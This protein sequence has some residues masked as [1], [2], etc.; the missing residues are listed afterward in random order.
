[1]LYIATGSK[2]QKIFKYCNKTHNQDKLYSLLN[3]EKI[4]SAQEFDFNYIKEKDNKKEKLLNIKN[5]PVLKSSAN[6]SISFPF[7]TL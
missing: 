7:T 4:C 5:L 1:M 6:S 3:L 2:F